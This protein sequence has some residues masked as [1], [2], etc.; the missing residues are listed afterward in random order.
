MP[1]S[2]LADLQKAHQGQPFATANCVQCHNPH[3]SN[4]P[5]LMQKFTH[6]PFAGGTCDTCHAAPKDGKVVLTKS[7]SRALCLTCHSEQ[8]EKI[9]KAAGPASGSARRM[10]RLPQ[11]SRRTRPRL[12]ATRPSQGLPGLPLAIRPTN[13]RKRIFISPPFDKACAICHEPH[14]GANAHLLRT[15]KVND[16]CLECHGPETPRPKKL[17]SEH[18]ITIFN[19]SVKLPDDYFVKNKVVVLPL[20]YGRGHP[21]TGTRFPICRT[22]R[23]PR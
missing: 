13:S 11:S 9:E 1:R 2:K 17:E 15:K 10:H 14:G 19:G 18:L 12:P 7:D 20:K 6:P 21:V 22:P 5:H 23:T 4:Q 3:Q 16:L 8:G